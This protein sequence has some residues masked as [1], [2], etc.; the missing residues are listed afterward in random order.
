MG[1]SEYQYKCGDFKVFGNCGDYVMCQDSRHC[2][3]FDF[4]SDIMKQA[5]ETTEEYTF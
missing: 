5:E 1:G 3:S 4:N 2:N